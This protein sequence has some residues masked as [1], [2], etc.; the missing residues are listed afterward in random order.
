MKFQ[1]TVVYDLYEI[2]D[3]VMENVIYHVDLEIRDDNSIVCTS[4]VPDIDA[5]PYLKHIGGQGAVDHWTQRVLEYLNDEDTCAE[6]LG[7]A[8]TDEEYKHW[9]SVLLGEV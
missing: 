6:V 9:E 3:R 5:I 7:E 2:G 8:M 4:A 1:K